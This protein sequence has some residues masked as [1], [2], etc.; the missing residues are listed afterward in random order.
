[1]SAVVAG[2][3]WI[4]RGAVGATSAY[5]V[6]EVEV[7]GAFVCLIRVLPGDVPCAPFNRVELTPEELERQFVRARPCFRADAFAELLDVVE[8]AH[9]A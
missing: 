9:S 5:K 6:D 7:D 2:S 3:Y 4:P 1:V 8:E